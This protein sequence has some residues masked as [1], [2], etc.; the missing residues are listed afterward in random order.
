MPAHLVQVGAQIAQ[1]L[2]RYAFPFPNEA[3]QNVFGADIGV[4]EL[5][6]LVESQ[7]EDALGPGGK[8]DVSLGYPFA[9]ADDLFNFGP[10]LIQTD[11][12]RLQGPC[13]HTFSLGGQTQQ[14]VLG[15]YDVMP[16]TPCLFLG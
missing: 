6:R 3:Q 8:A 12:Y 10:H 11:T 15:S 5:P 13:R 16:Q 14:N 1:H 7:L 2:S 4:A 9:A